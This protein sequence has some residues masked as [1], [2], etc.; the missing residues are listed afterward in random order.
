MLIPKVVGAAEDSGKF[1]V[2]PISWSVDDY[3]EIEAMVDRNRPC[4]RVQRHVV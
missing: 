3:P 4:P 2:A 1:A